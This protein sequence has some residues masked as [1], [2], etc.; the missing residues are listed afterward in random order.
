M[1]VRDTSC[2]WGQAVCGRK[3]K[4][5]SRW[6]V[7]SLPSHNLPFSHPIST[8]LHL[9]SDIV[10]PCLVEGASEDGLITN[11]CCN[12]KPSRWRPNPLPAPST[13]ILH[14]LRH[15][16]SS[17][18]PNQFS[19]VQVFLHGCDV[20]KMFSKVVRNHVKRSKKILSYQLAAKA[21]KVSTNSANSD[22]PYRWIGGFLQQILCNSV[23]FLC[24]NFVPLTRFLSK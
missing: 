2:C 13:I 8:A 3:E 18:L 17:I 1:G 10:Y 5:I 23:S 19:A 20:K 24:V 7:G 14:R 11:S 22:D 15:Y 21:L 12:V 6:F 4:S 16:F 9:T